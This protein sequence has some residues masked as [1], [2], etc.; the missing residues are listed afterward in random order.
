MHMFYDTGYARH[1]LTREVACF[2]CSSCKQTKWRQCTKVDMCGHVVSRDVKLKTQAS[3]PLT[4]TRVVREGKEMA[5]KV[6]AGMILGVKC[7]SEQVLLFIHCNGCCCGCARFVSAGCVLSLLF[8]AFVSRIA[9][10]HCLVVPNSDECLL[11]HWLPVKVQ[12][13]C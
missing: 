13:S 5:A 9:D 2:S 11:V 6:G 1:I 7:A 4:A 12:R 8:V 3:V 10:R